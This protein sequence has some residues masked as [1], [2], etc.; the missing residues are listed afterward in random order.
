MRRRPLRLSRA[1]HP[2]FH[3]QFGMAEKGQLQTFSYR[4][5]DFANKPVLAP[6]KANVSL[7]LD[8]HLFDDTPT[9]TL[10]RR[11]VRDWPPWLH[12]A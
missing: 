2:K 10:S 7:L 1:A 4:Q 12:P 3:R 6:V 5:R 8:D 11:F 9:E